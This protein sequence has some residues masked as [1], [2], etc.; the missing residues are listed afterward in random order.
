MFCLLRTRW[1]VILLSPTNLAIYLAI[2]A[3]MFATLLNPYGAQ[4]LVFLLQT[5]T[6]PRP[7]IV[8]WN[9]IAITTLSCA[10]III[11][12]VLALVGIVYSR[13]ERRPALIVLFLGA[14]LLPLIAFRHTPLFVLVTLA[15]AAEHIGDVWNR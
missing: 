11:L 4:L 9:P 3:S 15:L 8:E 12:L 13:R 7:E 2:I 14:A 10:I 6:V 5:A 1:T